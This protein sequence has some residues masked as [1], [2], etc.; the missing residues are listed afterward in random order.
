MGGPRGFTI[1]LHLWRWRYRREIGPRAAGVTVTVMAL[2]TLLVVL[3]VAVG[4][5]WLIAWAA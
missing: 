5:A 2:C 1:S 4:V 3:E